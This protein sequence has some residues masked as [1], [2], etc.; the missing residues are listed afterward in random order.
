MSQAKTSASL[1]ALGRRAQIELEQL[2][3]RRRRLEYLIEFID[4]YGTGKPKRAQRKR[5][6]QGPPS[7]LE[8]IDSR[9]GVRGSMLAMV[10]DRSLEEVGAELQRLEREGHIHRDGLGWSTG[11]K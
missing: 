7:L 11:N 9:P 4:E 8:V 10:V 5:R 3:D 2:E 6:R 1:S